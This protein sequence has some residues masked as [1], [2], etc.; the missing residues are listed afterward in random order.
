MKETQRV[1]DVFREM[2]NVLP[3][4]FYFPT[5]TAEI[6]SF[7]HLFVQGYVTAI[8]FKLVSTEMCLQLCHR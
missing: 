1:E 6:E 7:S 2:N 5:T 4:I 8:L 3:L